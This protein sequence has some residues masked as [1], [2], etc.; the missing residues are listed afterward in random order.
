MTDVNEAVNGLNHL[1]EA[2]SR[3]LSQLVSEWS[4]NNPDLLISHLP[5]LT[6]VMQL[7]CDRQ[8]LSRAVLSGFTSGEEQW[9]QVVEGGQLE[10]L[11]P[12]LVV[13]AIHQ[14]VT[15]CLRFSADVSVTCTSTVINKKRKRKDSEGELKQSD[16][17][18]NQSVHNEEFTVESLLLNICAD[19]EL[20]KQVTRMNDKHNF[21]KKII[22]YCSVFKQLVEKLSNA[23]GDEKTVIVL[24]DLDK[25]SK[26]LQLLL[27]VPLLCLPEEQRSLLVVALLLICIHLDIATQSKQD[28]SVTCLLMG[29]INVSLNSELHLRV[30]STLS[31]PRLLCRLLSVQSSLKEFDSNATWLTMVPDRTPL[32]RQVSDTRIENSNETLLVSANLSLKIVHLYIFVFLFYFVFK[33]N[34]FLILYHLSEASELM[35]NLAKHVED[36][37]AEA[38][39]HDRLYLYF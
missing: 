35:Q 13:Q 26:L 22:K 3:S 32:I 14:L 18:L 8:L 37:I 38:E 24:T 39:T 27:H 5:K 28:D 20:G 21:S 4:D 1:S 31:V 29:I 9:Q 11:Y 12:H 17:E 33:L 30:L 7:P 6:Q 2:A 36:D 10:K 23:N 25:C 16:D 15:S 34:V 19:L